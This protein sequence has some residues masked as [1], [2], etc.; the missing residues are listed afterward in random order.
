MLQSGCSARP[1]PN[2]ERPNEPGSAR[3]G[4]RV[5]GVVARLA[6]ESEVGAAARLVGEVEACEAAH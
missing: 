3:E 1:R 2:S 5:A 6:G 4:E